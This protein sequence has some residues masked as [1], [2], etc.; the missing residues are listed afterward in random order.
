MTCA[1]RW[2][3]LLV[4]VALA[5]TG[6]ASESRCTP[7]LA[8]AAE[9]AT[10]IAHRSWKD[11]H[12]Q[13]VR[14][15]KRAACDDGGIAEGWSDAVGHLLGRRW[16]E[17]PK[18]NRLAKS[19]PDFLTFVLKHIDMTQ[20]PADLDSMRTNATTACPKGC[21]KLCEKVRLAV[22][23]VDAEAQGVHR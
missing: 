21:E 14:Y 6:T 23:A 3:A 8:M 15:V 17:L 9:E 7:D 10:D 2:A 11:L 16:H 22:D 19:D 18:L 1:V 20:L 4:G 12:D 5:A 13:Y